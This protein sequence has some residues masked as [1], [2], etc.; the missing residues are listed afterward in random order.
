MAKTRKWHKQFDVMRG[1][2]I[3]VTEVILITGQKGYIEFWKGYGENRWEAKFFVD[4]HRYMSHSLVAK[5]VA[6]AKKAFGALADA[7]GK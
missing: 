4:L 7:M 2:D 1:T 6:E 5:S 3:Y